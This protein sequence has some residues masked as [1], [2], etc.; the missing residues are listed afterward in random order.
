MKTVFRWLLLAASLIS[1]V[2][3]GAITT[4]YAMAGPTQCVSQS[5][6]N[7]CRYTTRDWTFSTF[8]GHGYSTAG[9]LLYKIGTENIISEKCD[10]KWYKLQD[11]GWIV[12]FNTAFR[13]A[14]TESGFRTCTYEHLYI[15]ESWH[16]YYDPPR[17]INRFEYSADGP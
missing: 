15:S 5:G 9:A 13:D 12:S 10:G 14:L 6:I 11:T 7:M 8:K 17:G 1:G 16:N 3:T 2:L 4:Q